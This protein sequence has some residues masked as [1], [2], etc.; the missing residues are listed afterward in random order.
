MTRTAAPLALL[1]LG[2]AACTTQPVQQGGPRIATQEMPYR[3]G[4]GVVIAATKAPAPII[5]AAGGTAAP[6]TA[7][8]G[9]AAASASP[10]PYR[11]TIR[12]DNGGVQYVDTDNRELT[13]GSRVELG[14]DHTIRKL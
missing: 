1:A 2:L 9:T 11:L 6:A 12:M 3:A 7:Y 4:T 8:P 10:A 14:A 5:A 13:A